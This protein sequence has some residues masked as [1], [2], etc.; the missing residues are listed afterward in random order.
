MSCCGGFVV[1][2]SASGGMA[3]AP[4]VIAGRLFYSQGSV[5]SA[6][7]AAVTPG[8]IY[9]VPFIYSMSVDAIVAN[10]TTLVLASTANIGIYDASDGGGPGLLIESVSISTAAVALVTVPLAARR[11]I[12]APCWIVSQYSAAVTMT[13]A[14]AAATNSGPPFLGVAAVAGASIAG[15]TIAGAFGA[16]PASL[17]NTAWTGSLGASIPGA[18]FRT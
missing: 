16:L 8:T 4:D 5:P 14:G 6:T 17:V 18:F 12:D 9:A 3:M 1:P 7:L 15:Y 2:P 13:C 11:A 10:V